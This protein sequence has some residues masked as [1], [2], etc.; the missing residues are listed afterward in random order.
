MIAPSGM[1]RAARSHETTLVDEQTF[2]EV[3]CVQLFF[4][5]SEFFIG[6]WV[7]QRIARVLAHP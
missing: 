3:W 1:R 6:L 5:G 7:L 2:E 4:V